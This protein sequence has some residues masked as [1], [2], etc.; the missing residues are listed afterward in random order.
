MFADFYFN[1]YNHLPEFINVPPH[2]ELNLIVVIPCHDEPCI[3]PTLDSL[4]QCTVPACSVEV[5]V[6]VNSSELSSEQVKMSNRK[7]TDEIMQWSAVHNKDRFQCFI[8]Q[9]HDIRKKDAGVGFA[10]KTGMDE[11]LARFNRIGRP[12]GIIVSFDADSLCDS[13]YLCEIEES[14]LMNESV[15]AASVY[16]EHPVSGIDFDAK[17]YNGIIQYELHLRYFNQALKFCGFPFAYHTIGSSFAVKASV[18]AR[19]G[20]MNKK[21][22]GEDFY[23]LH[24]IIPLGDYFEINTTRVIPSSRPSH[25]VP[26]GTGAALQ[27]WISSGDDYMLTYNFQAFTDLD[28]FFKISLQLFKAKSGRVQ[29]SYTYLPTPVKQFVSPEQFEENISECN[30]HSATINNFRKRFFTWF[31]AF[32]IIRFLNTMHSDFYKKS[33]VHMEARKLLTALS[34]PD[35]DINDT[36]LLEYYRK[37]ERGF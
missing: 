22:A 2:P 8:I 9:L 27:K 37:L 12:D 18:Y 33:P 3:I 17:T 1:K 23:F 24:K 36:L 25:R 34:L 26:F 13:N 16:F 21:Q 32:K 30:T 7:S 10:R 28:L 5:I 19:Q 31:D 4:A 35:A 29:I 6:V 20:G 11:A 14:F 15:N